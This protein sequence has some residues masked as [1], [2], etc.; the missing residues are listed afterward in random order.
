MRRLRTTPVR[1]VLRVSDGQARR[2]NHTIA[3]TTRMTTRI[4]T[5]LRP[6]MAASMCLLS[7]LRG[8][9]IEYVSLMHVYEVLGKSQ[10]RVE[11]LATNVAHADLWIAS[12]FVLLSHLSAP[13]AGTRALS[14]AT[15]VTLPSVRRSPARRP[16]LVAP[17]LLAGWPALGRP[18]CGPVTGYQHPQGESGNVGR[19]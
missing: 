1:L 7:L 6:P 16:C 9:R 13:F 2:A 18:P 15:S 19:A 14:A 10:L 17:L 12:L 3:T 5:R 4:P 11:L 8:F